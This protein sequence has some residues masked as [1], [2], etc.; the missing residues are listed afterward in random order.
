MK[1]YIVYKATSKT[2][3]KIYIGI[4]GET[5]SSR[6]SKHKYCKG[7]RFEYAKSEPR[8]TRKNI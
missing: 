5:L 7:Y 8:K 4:T 6:I 2:T 3:K 1:L